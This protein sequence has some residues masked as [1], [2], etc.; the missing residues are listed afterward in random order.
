MIFE[1]LEDIVKLAVIVAT[2]YYALSTFVRKKQPEFSEILEK[3]R[4]FILFA[5]ILVVLAMK[6]SEDVIGGESG[7]VDKAVYSLYI[8]MSRDI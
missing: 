7:P 4:V 2:I 6:I 1:L 3:R 8:L 5:L